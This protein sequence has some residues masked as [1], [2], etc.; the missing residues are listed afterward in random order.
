M[1]LNNNLNQIEHIRT[2][3]SMYIGRLG[4]GTH[5]SDGV[6]TLLQEVL[7]FCVDEFRSGYGK[8]LEV[9]MMDERTIIVRDYG[10]GLPFEE[11]SANSSLSAR[12]MDVT[13][14]GIDTVIAL[15]GCMDVDIYNGGVVDRCYYTEGKLYYQHTEKTKRKDGVSIAFSLDEFI[16][17][18]YRFDKKIIHTMLQHIAYLN[19]GLEILFDG[20]RLL[21]KKGMAELLA[22]K[23]RCRG[24]YLYP[25]IH[26]KDEW[27]EV[28]LT[29]SWAS[30]E[31]FYSFVNGVNTHQGGAHIYAFRKA[32]AAVLIQRFPSENFIPEDVYSGMVGAIAVNVEHPVFGDANRWKLYS[33]HFKDG[34]TLPLVEYIQNF[35]GEKL[36]SYLSDHR[37]VCNLIHSKMSLAKR[38][39]LFMDKCMKMSIGELVNLWNDGKDSG[40]L[41]SED[42]YLIRDAFLA[43]GVQTI[44][45]QTNDAINHKLKIFY[46]FEDNA[47]HCIGPFI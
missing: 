8:K 5:Y 19:V 35:F 38:R 11:R 13:L 25:I 34:N 23:K 46:A 22:D 4:D 42:F 30:G 43:K 28:A 10:R 21:S 2:H 1:F 6:Y 27:V 47:I 41:D 18:D 24:Y 31:T 37:N 12:A 29:H 45:I 14:F 7:N 17:G 3:A 36:N 32:L 33:T 44:D 20:K 16:F 9:G 26:F 39:R 40:L 15:S